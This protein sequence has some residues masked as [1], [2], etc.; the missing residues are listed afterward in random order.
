LQQRLL[1]G[2]GWLRPK[3]SLAPLRAALE[4]ALPAAPE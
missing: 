2:N 4:G 1:S 3:Y